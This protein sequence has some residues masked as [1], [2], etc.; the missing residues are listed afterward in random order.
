M[1]ASMCLPYLQPALSSLPYL[2][3]SYHPTWPSVRCHL[4]RQHYPTGHSDHSS[5]TSCH[6]LHSAQG[7]VTLSSLRAE[8]GTAHPAS[9]P[10]VAATHTVGVLGHPPLCRTVLTRSGAHPKSHQRRTCHC[11][12]SGIPLALGFCFPSCP[13]SRKHPGPEEEARK[14]RE[15]PGRSPEGG[16]GMGHPLGT[17][18]SQVLGRKIDKIRENSGQG[19]GRMQC[20]FTSHKQLLQSPQFCESMFSLPFYR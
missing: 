12:R 14:I 2:S 18:Q 19:P 3:E 7:P 16:S 13:A 6:R 1:T 20:R 8:R 11:P 15:R 4:R 10:R 9:Q 5:T 17:C